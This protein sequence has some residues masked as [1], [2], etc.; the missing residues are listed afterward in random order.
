MKMQPTDA[1]NGVE[2]LRARRAE[3]AARLKELQ[4]QQ[5]ELDE[6]IR[7]EK[8]AQ[9]FPKF[10]FE[11]VDDLIK[12]GWERFRAPYKQIDFETGEPE[13]E[14]LLNDLDKYPHIYV[15]GCIINRQMDSRWA[16]LA[17]FRVGSAVGGWEF[18]DFRKITSEQMLNL[19]MSEKLGRFN[20]KFAKS[21]YSAIWDIESKYEG[22]ASRIWEDTPKSAT[23]VRRFLEFDGAGIKIATM[24][25]NILAAQF[26]VPMADHSSIDISPD[27]RVRNFLTKHQLIRENAKNEEIMYLAREQCPEFPGI[28]DIIAWEQGG[29]RS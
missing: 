11:N 3:N 26:K 21:F 27:S 28:F 6:Q 15:L 9:R 16:F 1:T 29:K 24:A 20:E 7:Q 25:T 8:Q 4:E 10:E 17:P 14:R 22:I 12:K 13:A 23:V 19:F 2:R 18:A 5:R